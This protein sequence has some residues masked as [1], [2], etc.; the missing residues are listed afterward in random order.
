MVDMTTSQTLLRKL[1]TGETGNGGEFAAHLRA[2]ST[3]TLRPS[4][5]EAPVVQ[6]DG[7]T[8][9]TVGTEYTGWADVADVADTTRATIASAVASGELDPGI[10]YTVESIGSGIAGSQL[11]TITVSGEDSLVDEAGL[12][13]NHAADIAEKLTLIAGSRNY[14]KLTAWARPER[15]Y[16]VK[17]E[18]DTGDNLFD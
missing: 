10:D 13:S 18:F 3:A 16:E 5:P 2:E 7:D 15:V 1:M 8:R 6:V 11:L 17:V 4:V 14:E 9:L 12:L